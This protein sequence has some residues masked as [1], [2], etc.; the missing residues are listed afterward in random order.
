MWYEDASI[1]RSSGP[2]FTLH[3]DIILELIIDLVRFAVYCDC[4]APSQFS[5]LQG[6]L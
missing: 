5:W 2:N 1:C 3:Q 6:H 4:G